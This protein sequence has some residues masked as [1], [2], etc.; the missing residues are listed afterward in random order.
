MNVNWFFRLLL[1]I[2]AAAT[3]SLMFIREEKTNT[4]L[5]VRHDDRLIGC[6]YVPVLHT[7]RLKPLDQIK[8]EVESQ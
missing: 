2:V 8:E 6:I 3:L 4:I 7:P 5:T 1:L